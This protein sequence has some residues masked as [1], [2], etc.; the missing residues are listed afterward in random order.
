M[1][2]ATKDTELLM[3]MLKKIFFTNPVD[4]A[5][6]E[7]LNKMDLFLHSNSSITD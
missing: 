1:Y 2:H 6:C 7:H 4:G 5:I 3:V